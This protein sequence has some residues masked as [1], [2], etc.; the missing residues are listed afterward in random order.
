MRTTLTI[1]GL[2]A[3]MLVAAACSSA[4]PS[5]E[6]ESGLPDESTQLA[7]AQCMRDNGVDDWPDPKF[8][9]GDWEIRTSEGLDL[10]SPTFKSAEAECARVLA[11][12]GP[13]E[14]NP[15]DTARTEEE[16]QRMLDFAKCMREQGI[17]FPDP[18]LD[19]GG[20]SGP[21]GPIDG[22]QEGFEKARAICKEQTGEQIP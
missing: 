10:E 18:H 22:D 20:I 3:L 13:G 7:Y 21:A 15:Q 19:E 16:M 12:D 4:R 17:E 1:L 5:D 6:P 14:A 8:V 11:L 9:D 2:A